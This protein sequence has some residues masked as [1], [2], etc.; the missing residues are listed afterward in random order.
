MDGVHSLSR[1]IKGLVT[2]ID[3]LI[4]GRGNGERPA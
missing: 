2:R 4:R 1:D 3:A